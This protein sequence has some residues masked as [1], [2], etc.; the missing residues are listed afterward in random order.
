M[1][2]HTD[3]LREE[4]T[5]AGGLNVGAIAMVGVVGAVLV[6]VVAIASQAWFYDLRDTRIAQEQ[7]TQPNRQV[8]DYQAEQRRQL[9][10]PRWLNQER[11][12]AA[13]PIDRA[14]DMYAEGGIR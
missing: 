4:P 7:Y 3:E 13:I 1:A 9:E 5:S 14:M 12:R 8:R 11:T 10:T 2:N 6:V